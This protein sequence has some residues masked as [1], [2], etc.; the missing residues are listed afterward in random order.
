MSTFWEVTLGVIA[1]Y[2]ILGIILAAVVL[3]MAHQE[4]LD[5]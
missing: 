1:G 5:R 4:R 2:T 3:F